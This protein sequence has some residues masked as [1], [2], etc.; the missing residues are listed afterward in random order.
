MSRRTPSEV[1]RTIRGAA[2]RYCP[3]CDDWRPLTVQH[4][5]FHTRANGKLQPGTYCRQHERD[6]ATLRYRRRLGLAG[7]SQRVEGA[8]PALPKALAEWAGK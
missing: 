7:K 2:H 5:Y 1:L 8:W 3:D 6:R 4:F